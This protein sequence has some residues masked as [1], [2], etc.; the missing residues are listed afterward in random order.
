MLRRY[1]N[2]VISSSTS[3]TV[4]SSSNSLWGAGVSL[5][6]GQRPKTLYLTRL[7]RRRKRIRGLYLPLLQAGARERFAFVVTEE[8][9]QIKYSLV[10]WWNFILK[11]YKLSSLTLNA[12]DDFS[13]KVGGSAVSFFLRRDIFLAGGLVTGVVAAGRLAG[14]RSQQGAAVSLLLARQGTGNARWRRVAGFV[15]TKSQ[16]GRG[17]GS[18]SPSG[19]ISVISYVGQSF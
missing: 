14:S 10:W 9:I 12:E 13:S 7:R 8:R 2:T 6:F 17:T 18:A 4:I 11:Y 16:V 19:R 15:V 3:N 5:S 1:Q